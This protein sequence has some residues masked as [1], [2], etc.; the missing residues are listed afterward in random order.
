MLARACILAAFALFCLLAPSTTY[1]ARIPE[2]KE[3]RSFEAD[4]RTFTKKH[5][6]K[7]TECETRS[8]RRSMLKLI[9]E[10]KCC[11]KPA[12]WGD[13]LIVVDRATAAAAVVSFSA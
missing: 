6:G 1:A 5:G 4:P 10:V 2:H 9:K 13:P 12:T 3:L 7:G 11:A 8:F